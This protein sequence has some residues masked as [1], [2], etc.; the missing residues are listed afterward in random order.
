MLGIAQ[1]QN[2]IALFIMDRAATV[3][4]RQGNKYTGYLL[5][6]KEA[7]CCMCAPCRHSSSFFF[8]SHILPHF[9]R[10]HLALILLKNTEI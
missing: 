1:L 5:C 7:S 10:A 6:H 8:L 3:M 4:P 9:P 2:H